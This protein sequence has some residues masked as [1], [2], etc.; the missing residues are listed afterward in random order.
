MLVSWARRPCLALAFAFLLVLAPS[1][2]PAMAAGEASTLIKDLSSQ[3]VAIVSEKGVTVQE[4]QKRLAV[5]V[6]DGFDLPRIARFVLGRYWQMASDAERE[7]FTRIY[8]DYLVRTYAAR[9]DNYAGDT[10]HVVNERA[11][12]ETTILV[13]AEVTRPGTAEPVKV[14]WRVVK[15]SGSYK[16][17]DVSVEGISLAVTQREEFAA[18]MQR[19]GGKIADLIQQLRA[20]IGA[21]TTAQ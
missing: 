16:I 19:S 2:H 6:L 10:F 11:E 9:M 21:V 8:S 12:S 17:A 7:E 18:I 14:I 15:T 20:K 4:R 1:S 13:N 5:L 3:A